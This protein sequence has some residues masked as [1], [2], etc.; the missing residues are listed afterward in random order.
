MHS[1]LVVHPVGHSEKRSDDSN[2]LVSPLFYRID[3]SLLWELASDHASVDVHNLYIP[4]HRQ[5][6][7][8]VSDFHQEQEQ[9]L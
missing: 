3:F 7:E 1:E 9:L 2:T 6:S 8:P 4:N 5:V